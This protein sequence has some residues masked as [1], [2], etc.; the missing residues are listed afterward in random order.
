MPENVEK[1]RARK[2]RYNQRQIETKGLDAVKEQ[3]R[4]YMQAYRNKKKEEAKQAKMKAEQEAKP[5]P[6]VAPKKRS[7]ENLRK[8]VADTFAKRAQA[9]RPAYESQLPDIPELMRTTTR[10]PPPPPPPALAV[11]IVAVKRGRGRPRKVV[12]TTPAVEVPQAPK[13]GRGR[14]RKLP[15]TNT[16][17]KMENIIINK[18]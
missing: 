1:T 2:Q 10:M 16:E 11:P 17:Q 6:A 4:L 5:K 8:V 12:M 13:R 9:S 3:K 7:F 14:P 15:L 18:L